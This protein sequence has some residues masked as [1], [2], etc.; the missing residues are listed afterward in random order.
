MDY[1]EALERQL[2]PDDDLRRLL[3]LYRQRVAD[4]RL[5]RVVSTRFLKDAYEM[6]S[7]HG[8]SLER[9]AGKLFQGWREDEVRKVRG[10]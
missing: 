3:Q 5:Q 4:N 10:Y 9:A 2:C 6:V 8:W 1:N 7:V